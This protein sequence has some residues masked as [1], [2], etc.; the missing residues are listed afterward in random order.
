PDTG[1]VQTNATYN[2]IVRAVLPTGVS[3]NNVNYTA[4]ITATSTYSS[5]TTDSANDVLTSVT[6]STVDLSN[7]SSG[8]A[9]TG[10]EAPA[11]IP[12]SANPGVT[13]RFTLYVTNTSGVADTY[14]LAA[15]T[16]SAF[17]TLNL[18]G[19]WS[20]VFRDTSEAIITSTGVLNAGS[21]KTVYADVS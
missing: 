17:S 10:P 18:P 12:N 2:V 19:G 7:G 11:V 1:P 8:G 21:N 3:G 4:I 6:M 9:G 5:S 16:N 20:V 15:S 13:P 14:N